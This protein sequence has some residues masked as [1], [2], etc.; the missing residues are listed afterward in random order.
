[1]NGAFSAR[2]A[3]GHRRSG[4]RALLPGLLLLGCAASVHA[5]D[6][7]PD[8][9]PARAD[10]TAAHLKASKLFQSMTVTIGIEQPD[11]ATV[12]ERLLAPGEHALLAPP[13]PTAGLRF[14]TEGLGRRNEIGLLIDPASGQ[15]LQRS[16]HE[17]GKR[18]KYRIYRFGPAGAQRRTW[19]PAEGEEAAAPTAWSDRRE[20][21][22]P[23]PAEV[24]GETLTEPGTLIYLVTIS[25]LA[26][27]GDQ[28]GLHAFS[29]S[30]ETVYRID[31]EV[32][33][34]DRVKFDYRRE[35]GPEAGRAEGRLD[36]IRV[37]IRGRPLGGGN[38]GELTLLGMHDVELLLDPA[39]RAPLQL[40]GS[41]ALFGG[42]TFKLQRL[43]VTE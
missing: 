2:R 13:S 5:D 6:H 11:E 17:T 35:G 38:D 28:F 18:D 23:V 42:I 1:M 27:P 15:V 39:T 3:A 32:L 10:W 40:R 29:T 36:A 8:F 9:D 33:S 43:A 34:P 20:Q 25:D 21:W 31:A 26:A 4:T 7:L 14:T 19:R 37:A 22:F 41:V 30:D 24:V 16:S 12:A